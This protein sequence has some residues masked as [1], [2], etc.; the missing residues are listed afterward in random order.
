MSTYGGQVPVQ[1]PIP[2]GGG[3]TERR[4]E[5]GEGKGG[6][7]IALGII[8]GIIALVVIF[9]AFPG[10]LA[11]LLSISVLLL[12]LVAIGV[13]LITIFV[14]F[15]SAGVGIYHLFKRDEPQGPQVGYT[16]DMVEEPKRKSD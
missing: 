1:E 6:I 16:L 13:V 5:F 11:W 4:R 15:I 10:L 7:L 14:F 12:A 3:P 9:I 8:V 2:L